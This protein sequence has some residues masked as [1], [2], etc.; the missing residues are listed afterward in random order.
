V[1]DK[2]TYDFFAARVQARVTTDDFGMLE[3]TAKQVML[4]SI[5]ASHFKVTSAFLQ[6][7]TTSQNAY[8]IC[9]RVWHGANREFFVYTCLKKSRLHLIWQN[10]FLFGIIEAAGG[11]RFTGWNRSPNAS[12]VYDS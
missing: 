6:F 12:F 2:K 9:A 7:R 8:D 10:A 1:R 3:P 5:D 4:G 11:Q